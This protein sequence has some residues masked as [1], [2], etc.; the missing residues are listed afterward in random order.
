[1]IVAGRMKVSLPTLLLIIA[2]S[3]VVRG[4]IVD[5]S[6]VDFKKADS[7]AELYPLHSLKDL[8]ILSDKL[9]RPLA[10]DLEKFR[11]IFKWVCTNIDNDYELYMENKKK[12]EK[13]DGDEL[14]SWGKKFSARA[15]TILVQ[16]LR[17]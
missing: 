7:I 15:F 14:R 2:C 8:K 16:G 6:S 9:T 17:S 12:R 4:Q 13:L 10:G 3:T 1:L 11:A 5:L